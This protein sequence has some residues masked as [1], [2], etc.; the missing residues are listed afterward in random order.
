[1]SRTK[2][3]QGRGDA[4]VKSAGTA[5]DF[6]P[7]EVETM[8]ITVVE[9]RT[10]EPS[11]SPTCHS[12]ECQGREFMSRIPCIGCGEGL[13]FAAFV[14]FENETDDEFFAHAGCYA[15]IERRRGERR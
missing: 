7:E 9:R 8:R 3:A 5:L 6:L 4:D 11:C 13:G 14:R 10:L 2:K 15:E 1:M 12:M